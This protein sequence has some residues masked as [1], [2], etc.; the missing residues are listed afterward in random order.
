LQ[1]ETV[2]DGEP[3]RE[4]KRKTYLMKQSDK[5]NAFQIGLRNFHFTSSDFLVF[6]VLLLR[7]WKKIN[8][9]NKTF[10]ISIGSG[11]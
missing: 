2:L 8:K 7:L 4:R 6:F 5:K 9:N 10:Q 11:R 1:L 3:E